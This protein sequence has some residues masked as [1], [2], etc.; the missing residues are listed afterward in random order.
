MS[1]LFPKHQLPCRSAYTSSH[2]ISHTIITQNNPRYYN[3][4][5]AIPFSI[6]IQ[7]QFNHNHYLLLLLILPCQVVVNPYVQRGSPIHN[8]TYPQIFMFW[9]FMFTFLWC[10]LCFDP[11]IHLKHWQ[12]YRL[13]MSAMFL[14]TLIH[15]LV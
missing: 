11:F 7:S 12:T 13:I 1:R 2:I 10:L 15:S 4:S 5:T 8:G 6:I 3:I 14:G 9:Y